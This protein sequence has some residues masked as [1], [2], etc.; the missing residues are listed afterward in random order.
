M[1]ASRAATALLHQTGAFTRKLLTD[2]S[3]SLS[4]RLRGPAC[5]L[6]SGPWPPGWPGRRFLSR[7]VGMHACMQMQFDPVKLVAETSFDHTASYRP[8]LL[9]LTVSCCC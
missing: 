1:R 7:P 5:V 8:A 4:V 6:G 3:L 2:P 9:L